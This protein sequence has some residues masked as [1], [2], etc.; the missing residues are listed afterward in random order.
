M[1][2]LQFSSIKMLIPALVT[3]I[4]LTACGGGGGSLALSDVGSG[5]TGFIS[6]NVTAGPVGSANVTAYAVTAGQMGARI[7]SATTDV[8]GNFT[9]NVGA[10]AGSV[11]LQANGGSYTDEA[12]G[13]VMPMAN[14]DV[15]T[16]IMPAVAA[17]SSNAGVQITPL[18]AMA[19]AM[20][21][22]MSG[23]MT[24]ANIAAAN[25]AIGNQ[26]SVGD[27]LHIQ[28]MNPLVSGSGSGASLDAQN[29]GMTLAAMS[30]YAQTLDLSSSSSIVTAMMNDASDGVLDGMASGASVQMV[31]MGGSMML[32]V[33]AG[34]NGMATA[35]NAF[36][37]SAQNKSGVVTTDLMSKLSVA[38]GQIQN[39]VPVT[40]TAMLRGT[41]FNGLVNR[42]TVSAYAVNGG[43]LGAQIAS[44]VVDGQGN[45]TMP[46][47]SYSG[48]VMLQMHGATYMDEATKTL[49]T[50]AP[51]D[52]MT[53]VLPSVTGAANVT[54]VMVTPVTSMAQSRAMGMSGGM[55]DAN[56]AAANAAMGNYFSI[57]D[58]LHTQPMDPV[59]SGSGANASQDA[60]NYGLTVAAMSEYAQ[61]LTMPVSSTLVMS[62]M[63]DAADG[64]MNGKN[65]MTQISMTM[66][67]MMGTMMAATVGTTGLADAMTSF[68]NSSANLSGL[69]L[70]DMQ[71]FMQKLN[72]SGGQI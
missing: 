25:L 47:G 63:Q 42:G 35:M 50:M 39:S 69:T 58:I 72:S 30:K 48:P 68:M 21:H 55:T 22:H 27:I 40:T 60:R 66:G 36:M 4:L 70:T 53:A 15:M 52:V 62:M 65:G 37:Y 45:F 67:T 16:A 28:P 11:M 44:A 56:M 3:G 49:M 7:G 46:L 43:M 17:G 34:T 57:N 26:F 54:G 1:S 31:G 19:Q 32:P 9:M 41:A 6:G 13:T 24:D 29:Y 64:V 10:Y 23:G 18:T 8:N 14:G 51:S 12:T 20:A 38:T 71:A 33:T 5:G 61:S 2:H 59:A